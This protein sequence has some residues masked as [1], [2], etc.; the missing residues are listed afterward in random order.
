M[1]AQ[2]KDDWRKQ[3][4]EEE[5]EEEDAGFFKLLNSP[6]NKGDLLKAGGIK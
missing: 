6:L 1:L 3:Q 2:L 4:E 5:E